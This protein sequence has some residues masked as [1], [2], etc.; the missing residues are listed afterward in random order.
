MGLVGFIGWHDIF[1]LEVRRGCL[2]DEHAHVT[3]IVP[4]CGADH[5][6]YEQISSE[7]N[8]ELLV[9]E[10]VTLFDLDDQDVV[11]WCFVFAVIVFPF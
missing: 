7:D 8:E 1:Q 6:S 10:G 2:L 5:E 3:V 11:D 4:V 9:F